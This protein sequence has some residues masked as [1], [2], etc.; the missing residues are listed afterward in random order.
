MQVCSVPH[1]DVVFSEINHVKS[2]AGGGGGGIFFWWVPAS[3]C[4]GCSIASC[5]FGA[6]AGDE[7]TSF[8]SAL[9]WKQGAL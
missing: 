4:D 5:D 8:Y 6:L 7:R 3:S 1:L 9:N 2:F